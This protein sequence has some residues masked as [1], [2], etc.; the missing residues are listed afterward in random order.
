MTDIETEK[1]SRRQQCILNAVKQALEESDYRQMT[2]EDIAA[3][4]GVGKSTIYR[5]W[6]HKSDLVFDAFREE[7]ASVFELDF[8]KSLAVNLKQQ[9]L[10]LSYALHK[11]VGRALLVVM[12]EHREAAG[13][14]FQHYLLPRRE[15]MRKLIQLGV[16]RDEIKADYPFELMLDS[17]YGPIHYQIIFFNQMPDEA[18]IEALVDMA[19]QPILIQG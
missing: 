12:A 1:G 10:K 14:F 4:A 17:L 19:L 11:P 16:E 13:Q 18:Y 7:T 9:L 3:R 8:E 2:V 6:K 5:W 15:Q